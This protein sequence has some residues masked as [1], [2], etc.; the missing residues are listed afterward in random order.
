MLAGVIQRPGTF[1]SFEIT[2]NISW[3]ITGVPSWLS[4]S[5]SSGTGNRSIVVTATSANESTD[6]RSATLSI[7]GGNLSASV[8]VTQEGIVID[9][10][11]AAFIATP[12]SG[13]VPL[14]VQFTDQSTNTPTSW[15]WDFGD[16]NTSTEQHPSHAYQNPGTYT[17]A[18]EVSND[19]GDD[20]ET[21][22]DYITVVP[23]D[24]NVIE[25]VYTQGDIPTDYGNPWSGPSA[26]PGIMEVTI[27]AGHWITGVDVSYT[28]TAA[29]AGWMSEQ[30]S[31]LYSPT[32]GKGEATYISGSG[33]S[34][35][36]YLYNRTG[37]AFANG[38][39]GT[40][41]F[42]LDAGRTWGNASPNTGCNTHYNKVDNNSWMLTVYYEPIP[43]CPA[44]ASLQ[45]NNITKTGANLSWESVGSETSWD[46]IWGLAG[47]DPA[48]S[49]ILVS[50][51][52]QPSY[53]LSGLEQSTFYDFYVRAVCSDEVSVW[54]GPQQF[55]TITD[56]SGVVVFYLS[57]QSGA[58]NLWR[59]EYHQGSLI[60]H[61]QLTNYTDHYISEFA[62]SQA[63]QKI[64]FILVA[65]GDHRGWIYITDIHAQSPQLLPN[66]PAEMVGNG[67]SFSPDGDSIVF[68]L[69]ASASTSNDLTVATVN[70]DGSN[71]QEIIS[72]H[73]PRGVATHKRTV[74]WTTQGLLIGDTRQW[75]SYTTMFD[76]Y[77]YDFVSFTNLTNT[78]DVGERYPFLSPNGQKIVYSTGQNGSPN[79]YGISV[80]DNN[81]LNKTTL[82]PLTPGIYY[83]PGG[84]L[85]DNTIIYHTSKD[86]THDIWQMNMDGSNQHKLTNISDSEQQKP[87]VFYFDGQVPEHLTVS[88]VAISQNDPDHCYS[89]LQTIT[90][91]G[92]GT[93]VIVE[94][95]A[96]AN[97]IAGQSILFKAGFH[98]QE[99]SYVHA[100]IT[101]DGKYCVEV[102]AA[103][104][105]QQEEGQEQQDGGKAAV[106]VTGTETAVEGP[107]TMLVYP[108]PNSG[109]FTVKFSRITEETRVIL[110]NSTGQMIFNQITADPE[111]LIDLP[112][113][114]SGMYVVKAVSESRQFS[115]K[116]VVK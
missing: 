103:I 53:Q 84:W 38:Q 33:S 41:V 21:K 48:N 75:A 81:G 55:S 5:H 11:V 114:T 69:G 15:N 62:V 95:G 91:A 25:V 34:G 35:G 49:G 40:I 106:V 64:A 97:F 6:P 27:P 30:R 8:Q 102:P 13:V 89:A 24:N 56:I 111:V 20:T 109:V 59:A 73:Q 10:P 19:G 22:V 115:R 16:Q 12:T 47:F 99:G 108:N 116:I 98:A 17:V 83:E 42:H 4:L 52:T 107:Q 46:V 45:A 74:N 29:N 1:D 94:S 60:N 90:V 65:E 54:T 110:F 80:M 72:S 93:E 36:T 70:T 87:K 77:L 43:S 44:P 3:S 14:T 58:N 100:H 9:P 31:R 57:N 76:V 71:Y 86:G 28:M 61:T 79:P 92:D 82:I 23:E 50:G 7:T 96:T 66:Q 101:T 78:T 104:V 113:I 37:L 67:V 2:S 112:G 32:N 63:E 18:L 51:I 88:G 39:T 26:C 68:T 85:D 105:A